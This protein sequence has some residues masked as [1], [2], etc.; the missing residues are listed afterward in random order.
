MS[1]VRQG[2]DVVDGVPI[3]WRAPDAPTAILVHVPAFGQ[4][5]ER[6]LPILDHAQS[7]GFAAIALDAYQHGAR[8]TEDRAALAERVFGN[9][10]RE[11]WT[12]IGET[13]L[14]VPRVVEWARSQLGAD[15]PVHLT[16]L[17][18]GGDVVVAA[19]PSIERVRSVNA[20]IATPDWE[21]PG[22]RD[23]ATDEIVPQGSPDAKAQFF[24]DALQPLSHPERYRDL[25][26]HF[27]VGELDRH[28]PAEAAHRFRTIVNQGR[29]PGPV[30]I[31]EKR[32]LA[33][34]DFV[35]LIWIDDLIFGDGA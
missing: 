19:A 31:T 8:G 20:V 24:F 30:R 22:M 33:H 7:L 5:K 12:I 18:M 15:L 14:D 2:E 16:G 28:V 27:I 32:G 29:E 13:A 6:A 26:T 4:T 21:R 11:M 1:D 35:A 23:I 10:R 9:F 34:L 17:S 3:V 25:L